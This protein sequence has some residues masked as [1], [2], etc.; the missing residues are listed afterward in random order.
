MSTSP[1]GE[2]AYHHG[3]LRTALLQAALA[4]VEAGGADAVSL[5]EV[6]RRAGVTPAA[7]YRHFPDKQALIEA[8]AGEG[9]R[10]LGEAQ[11]AAVAG[12]ADG[13]AAFAASGRAYVRFAR[14]NPGL[15]R[16]TFTYPGVS[17]GDPA[18]DEAGRLLHRHAL[19]L[20]GGD[21]TRAALVATRAWGLVH[22]LAM[23]VLDRRLADDPALIDAAIDTATLL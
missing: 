16:A 10:R 14:D 23:L 7:V 2:R 12:L 21:E 6:A 19:A 8:V 11:R 1:R 13:H 15:F 22:G 5:R 20:A 17:L 18:S 4:M 9:L 3:D